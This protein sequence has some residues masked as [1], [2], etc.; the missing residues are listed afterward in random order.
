MKFEFSINNE[1]IAVTVLY[2]E[3]YNNSASNQ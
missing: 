3:E 2:R 1:Q